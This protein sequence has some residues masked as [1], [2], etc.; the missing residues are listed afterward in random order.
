MKLFQEF[1]SINHR[2]RKPRILILEDV[3]VEVLK[4]KAAYFAFQESGLSRVDNIWTYSV[5]RPTAAQ[6]M[7]VNDEYEMVI[8]P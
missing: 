2:Q 4:Q 3:K 7:W 5:D 6:I 1:K 8:R